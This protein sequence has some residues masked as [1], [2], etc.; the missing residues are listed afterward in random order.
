MIEKIIQWCVKKPSSVIL[1]CLIGIGAGVYCF[2]N[3]PIDALPDLGD[4]QVIVYTEWEGQSPTL[5]EDQVTYPLVTSFLAAP[6]VTTV[7]GFSMMGASFVYLLFEEGTDLYWARSRTIEYLQKI[8]GELPEGVN[9]VLGPDATGLGW[10]LSYS[11]VDDSGQ[12]GI[13]ELRTYQDW[14]LRYILQSIP[15]VAEV[16][17]VGGYA[18]QYE[19]QVN[20]NLLVAYGI[21]IMEIA[22]KI[23]NSNRNA[24]G[25]VIE[26]SEREYAIRTLGNFKKIE[27]I[28]N[29]SIKTSGKG[30]TLLLKDIATITTTPQTRNGATDLNGKGEAVSG[31]IVMRSGE[32]A[33]T[34]ISKIKE[35]FKQIEKSLPP[36]SHIEITYDRS[37]VITQSIHTF[38]KKIIEEMIV[39]S[40]IIFIFLWHIRSSLV[41]IIL[42]PIGVILAFVPL[43]LLGVTSNIMSLAGIAI[44]IG[45]MVDAA[46]ILVENAHKK[47]EGIPENSLDPAKTQNLL[48]QACLEVGR[49]IFYSLLVIAVSFMPIFA[50]EGEEGKL[51][52]PLALTKNMSMFFASVLAITLGPVLVVKLLRKNQK[53]R[54]ED[55]HPISRFLQK[56][57]H[58]VLDVFLRHRKKAIAFSFL[59]MTS[60]I[61]LYH[62]LGEEFMPPLN[63]GDILYMPTT[64]PG[65]SITQ[66]Q[67]WLTHQNKLIAQFGEVKSVF[68]KVGRAETATDPAPLSMVE[69]VIQLKDPANWPLAYHSRWYSSWAPEKT[70]FL[71]RFLWPEQRKRTWEELITELNKT[72]QLPGTANAWVFPI[73][74]RI[75]MLATGIRTPIGIKIFGS[76]LNELDSIATEVEKLVPSIKGTRSVF[77]E[78]NTGGYYLDI[79]PNRTALAQHGLSLED[80]NESLTLALGGETLTTFLSGRARFPVVLRYAADFRDDVKDIRQIIIFGEDK[81]AIPL[82]Y[83]AEV[84]TT[85][86]PSMIKDENGFLTTWVLVDL[87]N[88]TDLQGFVKNLDQK[89]TQSNLFT[90]GVTYKISGQYEYLLRAK[91]KL[92]LIIPLTLALIILLLYLN[93]KSWMRVGLVLLAVPFS[94]VGAFASLYLLDYNLSLAV[95]VGILA[96]AGLDAETGVVMLLYLDLAYNHWKKEGKLKT[97]EDLTHAIHEGAVKRLRPKMMTALTILIGLFPIMISSSFETG[98]DVAKRMAAPMI[99]GIITSFIAE[100]LIYPCFFMIWKERIRNNHA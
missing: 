18:V 65:I 4:T 87:E 80:M 28:E 96:L 8:K 85:Y 78:R 25:R 20:P 92:M 36:G 26:I 48:I 24:E 59:F 41:P 13:E 47:L 50:L 29:I 10:I 21:S 3:T 72:V 90:K 9:P 97:P 33:V 57:Y 77:A 58:P 83:V 71:F 49:P 22:K 37:K 76:D 74:T 14:N 60:I 88:G 17:T 98:A 53:I 67:E 54:H 2:I 35:T 6:K 52:K 34:V 16:A 40:L 5:I 99:G 31:I 95:W 73:K 1:L 100:L 86:G 7:R 91:K 56:I 55:H 15:G 75:D 51:F 89:L 70:K 82:S 64:L 19:I 38:K 30:D 44:A 66:A 61:P 62:Y 43:Y 93:T 23:K 81:K 32:D 84:K 46:I 79:I 69:T 42:L 11:L 94:L 27:D 63:E 39:V 45:A 12:N 68:G